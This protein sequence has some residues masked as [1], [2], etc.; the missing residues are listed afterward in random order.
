MIA[1]E[2]AAGVPWLKDN[3]TLYE[4]ALSKKDAR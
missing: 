2:E 3:W 4:L 1:K